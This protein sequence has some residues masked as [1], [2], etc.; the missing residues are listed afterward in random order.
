M[1]H[2]ER[3]G[4]GG[5]SYPS[6][7]LANAI[8]WYGMLALLLAPWLTARWRWVI[9]IAPPVILTVTTV[10]LRFHW[11]TDTVAGILLGFVL[12]RLIARVPWD[13]VPL[14]SWLA[15]RGWDG[16]ACSPTYVE[17][18]RA[19]GRASCRGRRSRTGVRPARPRS[20]SRSGV[21]V[22]TSA[23]S[24]AASAPRSVKPSA[25]AGVVA[26]ARAASTIEPVI[27]SARRNAASM[28][29]VLPA[30]APGSPPPVVPAGPPRR[31]RSRPGR[32]VRRRRRPC[33]SP[34]SRR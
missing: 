31:R 19:T 22:R 3:F 33:R 18:G 32:R 29:S 16:P 11:L 9:R 14:G 20:G 8:V 30:I 24:P 23:R 12:W 2:P 25:R 10:Y 7:H 27:R 13:D 15:R 17:P 26:A 4:S 5:V 28:V 21:H 6:G 34:R 1:P